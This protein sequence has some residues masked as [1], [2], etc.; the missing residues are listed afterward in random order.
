MLILVQVIISDCLSCSVTFSV[1]LLLHEQVTLEKTTQMGK[2]FHTLASIPY[3]NT[4]LTAVH[5]FA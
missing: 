3:L 1:K 5:N 4:L 2:G